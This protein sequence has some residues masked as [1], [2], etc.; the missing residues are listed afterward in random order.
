MAWS[1]SEARKLLDLSA[2]V[3]FI[4]SI[5]KLS[6]F[7]MG[8]GRQLA[9]SEENSNKVSIY[10]KCVPQNMPDVLVEQAYSPTTKRVG[11]HADLEGLISSLGYSE[12]AYRV[13]VA[14][15][16]GLERLIYWYKY[17]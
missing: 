6:G 12:S 13:N 2:N 17:V 7:E 8:S 1:P 16:S 9:L 4:R 11:R 14:S 5:K 15:K 10:M 3:I